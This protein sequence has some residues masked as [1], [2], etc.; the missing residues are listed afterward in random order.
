MVNLEVAVKF[1][2]LSRVDRIIIVD[3]VHSCNTY[4]T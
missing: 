2:E 1:P 4:F 3:T